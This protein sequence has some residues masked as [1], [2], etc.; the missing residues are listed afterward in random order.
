[1]AYKLIRVQNGKVYALSHG[2]YVI[3]SNGTFVALET[4][5]T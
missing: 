1:V 3:I 5:F 2:A 4:Q